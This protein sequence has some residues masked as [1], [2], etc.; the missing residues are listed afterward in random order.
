MVLITVQYL[1]RLQKSLVFRR[2]LKGVL[3]S[4]VGLLTA[5]TLSFGTSLSWSIPVILIA[6]AAFVA[7]RFKVD[8]LWVVLVG[9]GIS[10]ALL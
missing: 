3:A 9:A 1:D 8:L 2:A 4:F 7:L 5:V 6:V 10:A